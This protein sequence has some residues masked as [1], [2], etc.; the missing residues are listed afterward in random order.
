MGGLWYQE[1]SSPQHL[2]Q[3]SLI[4]FDNNFENLN[5]WINS[6]W[7][8]RDDGNNKNSFLVTGSNYEEA[9]ALQKKMNEAFGE[10]FVRD[11]F[12]P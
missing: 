8:G 7:L 1:K 9:L 6:T 5:I 12:V 3:S 10:P 2:S 4:W 11:A